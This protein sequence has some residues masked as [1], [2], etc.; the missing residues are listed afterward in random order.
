MFLA[1]LLG[2]YFIII[3]VLV[4]V[5]QSSMLKVFSGL[6]K[7]PLA[8]YLMAMLELVAGLGLVLAYPKVGVTVPGLISLIGYMMVVES[9]FYL[10]VPLGLTK[11]IIHKF[12]SQQWYLVG[13]LLSIVLGAYLAG[14]AFGAF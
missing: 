12:N 2:L 14:T 6:T 3:G 7:S 8:L 4:I 13:G 9:V 10:G 11:K 5:R 1:Q